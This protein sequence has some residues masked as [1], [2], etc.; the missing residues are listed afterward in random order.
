MDE[1]TRTLIDATDRLDQS[2]AALDVAFADTYALQAKYD[3]AMRKMTDLI[4]A[5]EQNWDATAR[6]ALA[7]LAGRQGV[8][9]RALEKQQQQLNKARQ[10]YELHSDSLSRLTELYADQLTAL[11]VSTTQ[12][13]RRERGLIR[14]FERFILRELHKVEAP[15]DETFDH[16][17]GSHSYIIMDASRFLNLMIELD[18]YLT[19]DSDFAMASGR[20]RPVKFLEVGSGPGRNMGF[21]GEGLYAAGGIWDRP[22]AT[23]TG[24][25]MGLEPTGTRITLIDDAGDL[26]RL[27]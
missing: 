13:E 1:V 19:C 15:G 7:S 2:A 6:S 20:Y 9:R 3:A 16:P 22:Y 4:K 23:H 11:R 25:F 17:E 12:R 10:T 27:G 14:C 8:N 18:T 26:T 24:V 5:R 21:F